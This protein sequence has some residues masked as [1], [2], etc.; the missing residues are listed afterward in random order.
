MSM[1]IVSGI[2]P[3]MELALESLNPQV[4]AAALERS[5]A[6]QAQL[7]KFQI[8]PP[9]MMQ[10]GAFAASQLPAVVNIMGQQNQN[11]M[12]R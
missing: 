3:A 8:T 12:A 6:R 9:S 10:S 4:A 2:D 11:A 7:A 1:L 5:L